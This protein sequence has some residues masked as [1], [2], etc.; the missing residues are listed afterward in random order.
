[1]AAQLAPL[2]QAQPEKSNL[3][4]RQSRAQGEGLGAF[5]ILPSTKLSKKYLTRNLD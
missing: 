2:K 4:P 5:D 3:V 1:M